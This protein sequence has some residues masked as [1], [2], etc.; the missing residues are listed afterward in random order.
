[1]VGLPFFKKKQSKVIPGKGFVP[2][3][4]VRE[5][6]SRGFS[7]PEMIDILRREGFSAEEID[8]ALT[9]ALRIGVTGEETG[10]TPTQPAAFP[11]Q[12]PAKEELEKPT[13]P[14]L[15]SLQTAQPTPGTMPQ[16]PETSL[17]EYY[18]NPAS[19]EYIDYIVQMRVAEVYDKI[20]EMEEK[21]S[22]LKKKIDEFSEKMKEFMEG[23]SLAQQKEL[24]TDLEK[25]TESMNEMDSRVGSLEKAF[26]ETLPALV[27]S[28]RSLGDLVQKMKKEA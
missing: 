15:Q 1:M 9:Q 19:E 13:L 23:K 28:V 10:P 8:Q 14:T 16:I 3:D 6:A 25:I 2:V 11:Q 18:M 4:R 21:H 26:K 12:Q 17:P 22:E 24:S 5:M 27:S 20:A 7:E